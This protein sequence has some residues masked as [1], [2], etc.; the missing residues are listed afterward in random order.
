MDE[1][2][3]LVF[4]YDNAPHHQHLASYP[5][6]KHIGDGVQESSEPNFHDVLLEISGL[7]KTA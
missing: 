5:H 7:Q 6:H 2:L 3:T 1:K 4:R